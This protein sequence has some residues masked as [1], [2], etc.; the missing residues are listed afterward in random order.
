MLYRSPAA[1]LSC[2]GIK[3]FVASLRNSSISS[4]GSLSH[5]VTALLVL[6]FASECLAQS[7]SKTA[8]IVRPSREIRASD[9]AAIDE[10]TA[11]V[12]AFGLSKIPAYTASGHIVFDAEPNKQGTVQLVVQGTDGL[13]LD[14]AYD[15]LSKSLR[16]D[17]SGT[18][19]KRDQ[20]S[21]TTPVQGGID[22]LKTFQQ[23]DKALEAKSALFHDEGISSLLGVA[24]HRINLTFVKASKA[25][26]ESSPASTIDT[27]AVDCFFDPTTHELRAVSSVLSSSL[28]AQADSSIVRIEYGDYRLVGNSKLPF[29]ISETIGSQLLWTITFDD[30]HFDSSIDKTSFKF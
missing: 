29:R 21:A 25:R 15:G 4:S 17:S 8:Q 18:Y 20:Q 3:R 11:F 26:T 22:A 27:R 24:L 19:I 7:S 16:S 6:L 9:K 14:T 23:L 1:Y 12:S 13:R 28:G 10:V 5:A 2:S 30:I